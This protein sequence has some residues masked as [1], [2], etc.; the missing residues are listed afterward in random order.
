MSPLGKGD[1][2]SPYVAR[3]LEIVEAS[4]LDYRLHAMG[5]IL[6]GEW[7]EVLAVVTKCY[8]ALRPDCERI[9]CTMKIDAREKAA[10]RLI[11]KVQSVEEKLGRKLKSSE[12]PRANSPGGPPG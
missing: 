11:S 2:V 3:C 10:G 6:E 7:D 4:G 12:L 1:S 9:S 5:T 8:A